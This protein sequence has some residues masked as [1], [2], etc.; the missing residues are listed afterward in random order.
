MKAFQRG[1]Q[2]GGIFRGARR[3][4]QNLRDAACFAA[5]YE[6]GGLL[7]LLAERRGSPNP[8]PQASDEVRVAVEI[9]SGMTG[10]DNVDSNGSQNQKRTTKNLGTSNV[11]KGHN[12]E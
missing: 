9:P 5:G 2:L 11:I 6:T 7:T 12:Q 1:Q 4:H 3:P 8:D 10:E